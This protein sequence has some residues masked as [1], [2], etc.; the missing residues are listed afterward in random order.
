MVDI[1][2]LFVPFGFDTAP[3]REALFDSELMTAAT[4]EPQRTI[5]FFKESRGPR[6]QPLRPVRY[7]EARAPAGTRVTSGS[8]CMAPGHGSRGAGMA[9]DS[10]PPVRRSSVSPPQS[11]PRRRRTFARRTSPRPASPRPLHEADSAGMWRGGQR[12]QSSTRE[13]QLRGFIPGALC[14]P[15]YV[16]Q[17]LAHAASA[18]S[19]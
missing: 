13:K 8:P 15:A 7:H 2:R 17:D 11:H 3:R 14:T 12:G 19:F 18:A 10:P 4:G 16:H 9:P 1:T 5:H 6:A